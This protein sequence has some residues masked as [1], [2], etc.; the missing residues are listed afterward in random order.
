MP[1]IVIGTL[2]LA[3]SGLLALASDLPLWPPGVIAVITAV[4]MALFVWEIFECP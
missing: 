4:G 3:F 1:K 2:L